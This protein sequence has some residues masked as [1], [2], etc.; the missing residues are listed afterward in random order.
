MT[1]LKSHTQAAKDKKNVWHLPNGCPLLVW[2]LC[3]SSDSSYSEAPGLAGGATHAVAGLA[4]ALGA[5]IKSFGDV[6]IVGVRI[7]RRRCNTV[8]KI[9][10]LYVS[11]PKSVHTCIRMTFLVIIQLVS[12]CMGLCIRFA[13]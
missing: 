6:G 12:V 13:F 10:L 1:S 8:L 9:D 11:T 2:R 7:G 3:S 5:T 4:A